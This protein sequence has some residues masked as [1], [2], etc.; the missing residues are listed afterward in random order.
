MSETEIKKP[1][2]QEVHFVYILLLS[3]GH[4][5]CGYTNDVRQR[6]QKH[7]SGKGSK[8]VRSFKPVMIKRVWRIYGSRGDAL[9]AESFVKKLS[10]AGKESIIG[11]PSS[12]GREIRRSIDFIARTREVRKFADNPIVDVFGGIR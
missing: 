6:I 12:F 10:R 2:A 1:L 5:Y 4:Y 9:K 11:N 7:L 3:N 8:C